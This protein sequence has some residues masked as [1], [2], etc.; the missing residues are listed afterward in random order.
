MAE[1]PN[2]Y[3]IIHPML[4][5]ETVGSGQCARYQMIHAASDSMCCIC[6]VESGMGVEIGKCLLGLRG[7]LARGP[8]PV[9]PRPRPV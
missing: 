1:R 2:V 8:L 5:H 3:P 6:K 9:I 4:A 7:F